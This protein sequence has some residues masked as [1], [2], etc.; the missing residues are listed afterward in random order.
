VDTTTTTLPETLTRTLEQVGTSNTTAVRIV[1]LLPPAGQH[2]LLTDLQNNP[3]ALRELADGFLGAAAEHLR[4]DWATASL[5][6]AVLRP[7]VLR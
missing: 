4:T 5:I 1:G 2:A 7:A 6:R 3:Y